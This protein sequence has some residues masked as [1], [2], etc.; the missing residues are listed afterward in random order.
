MV[1]VVTTGASATA[2]LETFISP[3]V[4]IADKAAELLKSKKIDFVKD[5]TKVI[6]GNG[7]KL[8]AGKV[9]KKFVSEAGGIMVG[10]IAQEDLQQ[11]ENFLVEGVFSPKTV[12]DRDLAKELINT[13][14]ET[15][16]ATVIPAILGGGG[17]TKA[18]R[19]LS[20][21]GLHTIAINFDSYKEAMDKAV[22]D[23]LMSQSD[24]DL[25]SGIIQRHKSNIDNAPHRDAKGGLISADRQLE[26][27]FQS[28][29][30]QIYGERAAQQPDNVQREPLE[31]KI[32]EAEQIKRKIFLGEEV[33]GL[34]KEEKVDEVDEKSVEEARLLEIADQALNNVAPIAGTD[35]NMMAINGENLLERAVGV[36]GSEDVRKGVELSLE[37]QLQQNRD[38]L[39]LIENPTEGDR[40][41]HNEVEQEIRQKHKEALA[42][43]EQL[44]EVGKPEEISQPIEPDP[45]LPEGGQKYRQPVQILKESGIKENNGWERQIDALINPKTGLAA[46]VRKMVAE[47]QL[48]KDAFLKRIGLTKEEYNNFDQNGKDKI[49]S[50]W[51]KSP[52]FKS[53]EEE[54]SKEAEQKTEQTQKS[55]IN[56]QKEAIETEKQ[57]AITEATKP[58]VDLELLGDEQQTI[59]LITKKASGDNDGGKAKI[60]QHERI[61]VRLQ[62]LKDLID[63]V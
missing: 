38:E 10:Q 14:K 8:A 52:E 24:Y 2:A 15:A 56:L 40:E 21:E 57:Q 13:T 42:K 63:C 36:W 26:Y 32:K 16:L 50:E 25:A 11:V 47:S 29:V 62:A 54:Q 17:V 44:K 45:T 4:K 53:L 30:E 35:G 33:K 34:P 31:E 59:D 19:K 27:A 46:T 28:T 1:P 3:D 60:R 48:A 43:I 49:Q 9:V 58:V 51:V 12:E 37:K 41:Y 20:R 55:D 61:R 7:G 22:L 23:G 18:H 6:E 39:S 5:L